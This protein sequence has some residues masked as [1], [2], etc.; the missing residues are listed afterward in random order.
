MPKA[1]PHV[2][3]EPDD[4]FNRKLVENVHPDHWQTPEPA[5]RYN[6]VVVG[7]GTAGLVSAAGA[8]LMGARV[9]LVERELLGGDCLNLGCVPSKAVIRAARAWKD[10]RQGSSFGAPA[11][12]EEGASSGGG[13]FAVVMERMRRLRA[14]ISKGD[15]VTRFRDLG[16]DIF[17]GEGRFVASDAV[18]VGDLQLLFRRAVGATGGRPLVP[19]IPGLNEVSYLTN[20]TIFSLTELP[21][22]LIVVGGGPIGCELAQSFARFGSQVTVLDMASQILSKEDPEA[23][24]LVRE[25]LE[26]DGVHF[27]LNA[28]V[29]RVEKSEEAT[30]VAFEQGDQG[31][32]PSTEKT[33][34]GTA[35]L[36]AI[37][38]TPNVEGLGLEAAGVEFD[39]KGIDV[40]DT[41]RTTNRRIFAAGDVASK[42]QFTHTA[43]AQARI[44]LRNALFPFGSK[45]ASDLVI[46]WCTYTSPEIAHV[47]L[48]AEEA[49]QEGDAVDTLTIPLK[50]NDR[51]ILDGETAG[52]LRLYSVAG[53]DTLLGG[54]L[55]AEHAGEMIS[56]LTLAITNRLGLKAIAK[57]IHPYPTQSEVFK[58]AGDTRFQR[59]LTPTWKSLLSR[60]FRW[61]R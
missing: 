5:D 4:R 43:D 40:D 12:S 16:V 14:E 18:M 36:L 42:Y 23:A 31:E 13:N 46:P 37:G 51:A 49:K 2:I 30:R 10:A 48:T 38:R 28:K 34:E 50:G 57:T 27:E 29:V 45:K 21:E 58:A 35:L 26:Q 3:L 9:A 41:L 59:K 56:E 22:S 7:G 39:R 60:F 54:T 47:G 53:K 52:F 8:A 6:L 11:V 61:Q 33:V 24:A 15:S 20:E 44:V 19:P 25:S 1:P 32:N 17:L 55:V